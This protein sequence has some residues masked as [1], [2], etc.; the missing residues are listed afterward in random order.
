MSVENNNTRHTGLSGYGVDYE[1]REA[2][3]G[4]AISDALTTYGGGGTGGSSGGTTSSSVVAAGIDGSTDI[5]TLLARVASIVTNTGA[6][7]I[8]TGIDASADINTIIS[9]LTALVNATTTSSLAAAINASTDIDTIIARLTTIASHTEAPDE[10]SY[11]Y[12]DAVISLNSTSTQILSADGTRVEVIV[13][14]KS[15]TSNIYINNISTSNI[16]VARSI[17]I[18]PLGNIKFTDADS[19]RAIV[20]LTATGET[21]S[22]YITRKSIQ[23][24]NNG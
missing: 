2:R 19:K 22:A 21:A 1:A 18:A 7:N 3:F 11:T 6:T 8:G 17:T 4:I 9:R 10:P 16:S 23:G 5:D 14:N 20:G 13:Q 24:T 12:S 15:E